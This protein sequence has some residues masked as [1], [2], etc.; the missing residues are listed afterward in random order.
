M[1]RRAR[2]VQRPIRTSVTSSRTRGRMKFTSSG[3]VFLAKP[4][5]RLRR[6]ERQRR[7]ER[8]VLVHRDADENAQ[9]VDDDAD[10]VLL[11][12]VV[13]AEQPSA[14][15]RVDAIS[16]RLPAL[17]PVGLS[18]RATHRRVRRA[19]RVDDAS[20]RRDRPRGLACAGITVQRTAKAART[21]HRSSHPRGRDFTRELA[22]SCERARRAMLEQL[23]IRHSDERGRGLFACAP[24]PADSL[25]LRALPAAVVADDAEARRRWSATASRAPTGRRAREAAQR[26][27]A[28]AAPIIAARGWST[29]TSAP[30]SACSATRP[31]PTGP[32]ARRARCGC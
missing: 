20:S 13:P 32:P 2:T 19:R 7:H 9:S 10:G 3:T 25:V 5:R 30:R 28:S 12:G 21:A 16:V 22:I 18:V 4:A 31:P 24:L 15:D 27:S 8:E 23:E 26:C 14:Q 17:G 6:I 29:T 1:V 11:E